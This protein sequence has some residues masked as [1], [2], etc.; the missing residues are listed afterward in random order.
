MSLNY[1][2]R[3]FM[4]SLCVCV[5]ASMCMCGNYTNSTRQNTIIKPSTNT[6]R[7]PLTTTSSFSP[8]LA[9]RDWRLWKSKQTLWRQ[10]SMET[11]RQI[12][13][14]KSPKMMTTSPCN[15]EMS[16]VLVWH[17]RGEKKNAVPNHITNLSFSKMIR[18]G[19]VSNLGIYTVF[20]TVHGTKL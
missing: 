8:S 19:L 18:A 4:W 9:F 20:Y 5:Y 12:R 2:L 14:E 16:N 1:P 11:E 10:S 17:N 15:I 7:P 6:S 3:K 13:R